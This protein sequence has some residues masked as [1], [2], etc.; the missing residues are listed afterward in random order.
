MRKRDY[1][2][3]AA[4][5]ARHYASARKRAADARARSDTNEEAYADGRA[6]AVRSMAECFARECDTINHA[7]FMRACGLE[8]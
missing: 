5:F 8:P 3:L 7:E 4:V 1:L 2:I 6:D